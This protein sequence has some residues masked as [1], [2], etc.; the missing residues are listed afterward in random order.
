MAEHIKRQQPIA[1]ERSAKQKANW[2]ASQGL[3]RAAMV[4]VEKYSGSSASEVDEEEGADFFSDEMRSAVFVR[5]PST[6]RAASR[7][8][9][10][11][12]IRPCDPGTGPGAAAPTG[13]AC[14]AAAAPRPAAPP[15]L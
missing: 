8:P 2:L 7:K 15:S 10:P 13:R 9:G 1:P 4:E 3:Y 6:R 14:R 12:I 5:P 11:C